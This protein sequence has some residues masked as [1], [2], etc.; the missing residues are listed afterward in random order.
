[1]LFCNLFIERPSYVTF[2]SYD[3]FSKIGPIFIISSLLIQ[4]GTVQEA[5]IKTT[6]APQSVATLPCKK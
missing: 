3:N 5:G 6:T 2:I 4:Q 1:M